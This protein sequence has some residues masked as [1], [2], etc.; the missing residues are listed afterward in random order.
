VGVADVLQEI[1][2]LVEH[3]DVAARLQRTK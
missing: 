1:A 3:R 2:V